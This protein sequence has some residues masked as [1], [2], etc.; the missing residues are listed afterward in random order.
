MGD[1]GSNTGHDAARAM[2]DA[3]ASVG[4]A[5]FDLTWTTHAGEKEYFRAGV[6][7]TELRKAMPEMLDGAVEHRRNVIVR[8]HGDGVT[9]IQLDDLKAP[10]LS[11][12]APAVFLALQTSPGNF[13][14]WIAL[15]GAQDEEFIRRLKRGVGA[16]KTASGATRVAGSVNFKDKYAP[17]FPRVAIHHAK[18]GRKTSAAELG[19]LG[20][21]AAPELR[22]EFVRPTRS[23]PGGNRK[24]PSYAIARERAPLNH[25]GSGPDTS[26]AD[27]AW[28]MTAITWGWSVDETARRLMEEPES[29]AHTRGP[30]YAEETARKA[31]LFV[32]QRKPQPKPY[33]AAKHGRR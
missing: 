27:I 22:P 17:E 20:L 19:R 7:L 28:C 2:F 8:P 32:A 33:R 6:S 15:D 11:R 31:D 3:F 14:A 26:S 16:D 30:R 18:P 9:F 12:L 13:Q 25:E 10:A 23:A 29:K 4:A 5:R 24:W 1:G 21:V